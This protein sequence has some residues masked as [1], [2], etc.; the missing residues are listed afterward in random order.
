MKRR[1]T[2]LGFSCLALVAAGACSEDPEPGKDVVPP[3]DGIRD[4]SSPTVADVRP[5]PLAGGTLL[6]T[7]DGVAVVADP[8]RDRVMLVQL[9]TGEPREIALLAG[10]EPGRSVEDAAGRVHVA[11]R[12]GGAIATIDPASGAMLARRPVC[13]AP[14]GIAHDP[15]TDL[16][17]VA[18]AGGELVSLSASDLGAPPIASRIIQPDLRDVVVANDHLLVSTLRGAQVISIGP[19]GSTE[20]TIQPA[21]TAANDFEGNAIDYAPSVAWRMIASGDGGAFIAHAMAQTDPI[22]MGEEEGMAPAYMGGGPP[23]VRCELSVLTTGGISQQLRLPDLDFATLPIDVARSAS[24]SRVAV[25]DPVMGIFEYDATRLGSEAALAF[26]FVEA[27]SAIAYAPDGLLVVQSRQPARLSMLDGGVVISQVELGGAAR[28]DTGFEL[29]HGQG[30]AMS[31]TG[32]ACASCHP[33]G[34]DDGHVWSFSDVGARRTQSL[35]GTLAGTAPFHWQGDLESLDALVDEV[36]MRRMGASAQSPERVDVLRTW[37]EAIPPVRTTDSLARG[38]GDVERGRALF[39]SEETLCASC[40]GGPLGT[41]S[42]TAYVG[43]GIAVQ[44]PSLV[45]VGT[46]APYMHDGCAQTLF[47][48]FEPACGGGD[49]HGFTS[50]LGEADVRDLVAYMLTL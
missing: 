9:P 10:D 4:E 28:A 26:G 34:R 17:H 1:L 25:L 5:P 11:L 21:H 18:C 45:G 13:Q 35:A 7:H 19:T 8:D 42:T 29:F 27:A 14:R 33:E 50:Q 39:E 23:L 16:L 3:F 47:E 44:V 41:N 30:S 2:H 15:A 37:L 32:L 31:A 12:R 22:D 48:R 46:R 40:H 38:T 24:T 43:T 20:T 49:L 36:M 6:V